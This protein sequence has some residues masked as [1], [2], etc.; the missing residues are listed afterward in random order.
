MKTSKHA[1][2]TVALLM[3]L[4]AGVASAQSFA[5]GV[6]YVCNGERL[7][8]ESCNMQNTSDTS[9]CLVQHPDRPLHNGF[10]A[11]TN[12]SRG[13]LNKLVPTCTQPSAAA[14][15]HAQAFA[16]KQQDKQ[17]A[18]LAQNL[19]AM[20]AP[21]PAPGSASPG[22][23]KAQ[24]DKARLARCISAGKTEGQC[25]GNEF[26][27]AFEGVFAFAGSMLGMA[28]PK[29]GIYLNGVYAGKGGWNI[30]FEPDSAVMQCS[31]LV[32]DDHAYKLEFKGSQLIVHVE[33]KPDPLVLT[34]RD[35]KLYGAAPI[36]VA[37]AI[38]VGT[39]P[40]TGGGGVSSSVPGAMTANT[41]T[42]TTTTDMTAQQAQ[43]YQAGG[44]MGLQQNGIGYTATQTTTTTTYSAAAP[45]PVYNTGPRV[46]TAP[47]TRTCS[48]PVL[49]TSKTTGSGDMGNAVSGSARAPTGLRVR[50][51]FASPGGVDIDF[52]DDSAIVAC[53]LIAAEYPY[54][55][56][57]SGS[58]P[59]LSLAAPGK[60]S[61]DLTLGPDR[62]LVG[63]GN[64]QVTGRV[65]TG[66]D[67]DGNII[68]KSHS[69]SCPVG[70]LKPVNE[71]STDGLTAS[72][73]SAPSNPP[74]AVTS[75]STNSNSAAVAKTS[76]PAVAKPGAPTGNAV[77]TVVS[78]FPAQAGAA[79]SLGG[80]P[81]LL[82]RDN[83]ATALT[84]A[85]ATVP[86]G[87]SPRRAIK[88]ACAQKTPDCRKYLLAVSG[89]AATGLAADAS[90]NAILPGVP[91]GI[92]FLVV[93]N[94]N[95]T[96]YWELKLQLKS[97]PN[98]VALNQHNATP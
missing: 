23:V 32:I 16:K 66:E 24:R 37:G 2:A 54:T 64:V 60:Y 74:N 35:G 71:N 26:G 78:G 14:V 81:Y 3:L 11:Y 45:T 67:R 76:A 56:D 12:E 47:R 87:V 21:T 82:L 65:A 42:Q 91:P 18:I 58:Q 4:F 39:V 22:D 30:N 55:F 93:S 63:S 6:T 98:S 5:T 17:D 89:D 92:Y 97:G 84:K 94:Q 51:E 79:N 29:S 72:V 9:T 90:G 83:L 75:A 36:Q 15:A 44:G 43:A 52:K 48:A 80:R 38:V 10:T 69:V 70:T 85:G 57:L 86:A 33:N 31:D 41:S 61:I 1:V 7:L 25:V 77:L 95:D 62:S 49:A 27:K 13:T 20:D 8:I 19:A 40:G 50:G 88:D 96:M 46:L 28:P 59:V 73:S 34:Y 53:G 68:Y